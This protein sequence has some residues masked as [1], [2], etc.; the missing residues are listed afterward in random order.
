MGGRGS[1]Y[2]RLGFDPRLRHTK[3]VKNG[4]FAL[5]SLAFGINELGIINGLSDLFLL[6][7]GGIESVT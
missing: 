3:D 4:R 7:C 1:K 6:T 2:G 5:L